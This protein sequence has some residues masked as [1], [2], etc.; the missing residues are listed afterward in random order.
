MQRP[1]PELLFDQFISNCA[2]KARQSHARPSSSNSVAYHL[3]TGTLNVPQ[4][5]PRHM[6]DPR[7]DRVTPELTSAR[8]CIGLDPILHVICQ[9]LVRARAV[10]NDRL[11]LSVD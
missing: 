11:Q 1:L 4:T 8:T 2:Q 3:A 5:V 7:G 9:V 6:P 10:L